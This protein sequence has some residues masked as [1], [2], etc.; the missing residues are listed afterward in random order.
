MRSNHGAALVDGKIFVFG[1]D[2][3]KGH[4]LSDLWALTTQKPYSWTQIALHGERSGD[5]GPPISPRDGMSFFAAD[6]A[7][8]L[9]GGFS[10]NPSTYHADFWLITLPD[11]RTGSE[12]QSSAIATR[13]HPRGEDHITGRFRHATAVIQTPHRTTAIIAGGI[14]EGGFGTTTTDDVFSFD[15]DHANWW[16][17]HLLEAVGMKYYIG[18]NGC[19]EVYELE[20][21]FSVI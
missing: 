4:F 19:R 1:G 14:T 3:G 13:L 2:D 10:S 15:L 12:E 5:D 16:L 9:F 11:N 6:S 21:G 20:K 7:L 8:V 17:L 18:Y